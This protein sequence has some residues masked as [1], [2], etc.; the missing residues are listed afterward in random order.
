MPCNDCSRAESCPPCV[1]GP[2]DEAVRRQP[3]ADVLA[4]WAS[5]GFIG[6]AWSVEWSPGDGCFRSTFTLF[7][8]WGPRPRHYDLNE[9]EMCSYVT[10]LAHWVPDLAGDA[11]IRLAETDREDQHPP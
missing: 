6:P 8:T 11:A 7:H 10:A 9:A 5:A 4:N 1:N 2:E 3:F